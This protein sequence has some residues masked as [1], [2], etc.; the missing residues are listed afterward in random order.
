MA[1][2][3]SHADR[4]TGN[5]RRVADARR[6][7]L[8]WT[9]VVTGCAIAN[10]FIWMLAREF[11]IA[12]TSIGVIGGLGLLSAS[13]IFKS[14]SLVLLRIGAIVSMTMLPASIVMLYA[15]LKYL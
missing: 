14:R 7:A 6:E 5:G 12:F 4:A 13:L 8:L 1:V 3:G 15:S 10:L 2:G 9:Y 11:S